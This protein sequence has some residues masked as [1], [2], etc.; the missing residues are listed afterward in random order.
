[1]TSKERS[2]NAFIKQAESSFGLT[3]RQAGSLYREFSRKYGGLVRGSDLRKHPIIAKRL[4]ESVGHGSGK[5]TGGTRARSSSAKSIQSV[6]ARARV[7]SVK[8]I[9]DWNDSWDFYDYDPVEYES[10]ADYGE[11]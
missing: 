8:T 3:K 9:A 7:S 1:M 4:A 2:K 5:T 10:S 6:S 11:V